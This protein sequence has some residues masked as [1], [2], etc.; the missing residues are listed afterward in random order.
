MNLSPDSIECPHLPQT[1]IGS[2][3]VTPGLAGGQLGIRHSEAGTER[4][5]IPASAR[6]TV[7]L[8]TRFQPHL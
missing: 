8:A 6:L 7:S 5:V 2:G 1:H 3:D 4:A